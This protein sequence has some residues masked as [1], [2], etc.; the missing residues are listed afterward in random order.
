MFGFG[1]NSDVENLNAVL[2][3]ILLIRTVANFAAIYK[4]E[5]KKTEA[6]GAAAAVVGFTGMEP[7]IRLTQTLIL[8]VWSIVESLVD[9]AGI[10]QGRNVP[11]VKKTTEVLT[12]FPEIFLITG[13]AITKRAKKLKK[14]GKASFGYREYMLLFLA[15]TK[16]STR[17][18]RVMDLIQWD[19]VKNGYRGFKLG[20]CVFSME[21][22][23]VFSFSSKF[24][25]F[26]T[27]E[28]MLERQIQE[29]RYSA[30]IS[31]GYL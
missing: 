1:K 18:Y 3:R 30:G 2:N 9:V 26:S 21:V 13:K 11:I 22:E 20:N 19:M 16:Q 25:R 28:E 8:L 17:R 29:Y 10:L 6:Y 5:A 27:I 7:L 15:T 4:D 23:G 31:V 14:A 12:S 24:F